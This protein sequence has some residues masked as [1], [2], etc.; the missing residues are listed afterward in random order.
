PG[1]QAP[2]LGQ[3]RRHR[4]RLEPARAR[5][6]PSG[7]IPGVAE[8]GSTSGVAAGTARDSE[9]WKI[10]PSI[11]SWASVVKE[12]I[13]SLSSLLRREAPAGPRL[14]REPVATRACLGRVQAAGPLV[15]RCRRAN[16]RSMR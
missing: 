5:L 10:G 2:R 15:G 13:G 7:S 16:T 11:A 14:S 3:L 8:V 12:A 6:T 1:R 4:P 9:G